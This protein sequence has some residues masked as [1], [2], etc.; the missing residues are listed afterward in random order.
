MS[1]SKDILCSL[2]GVFVVLEDMLSVHVSVQLLC[3]ACFL[4]RPIC[5]EL[6]ACTHLGVIPA[7]SACRFNIG[8]KVS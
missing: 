1:V 5:K 3:S 6:Y 8:L 2:F 4:T 7:Y